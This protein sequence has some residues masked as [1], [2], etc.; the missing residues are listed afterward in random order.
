M[1]TK[2]AAQGEQS[3]GGNYAAQLIPGVDG[4]LIFGF[5]N[6][7]ITKLRYCTN[8]ILS[9]TAGGSAITVFSANSIFDPDVTNTGHQPMYH[10]QY[11]AIYKN[12]A[13]LGSRIQVEFINNNSSTG[14]IGSITGDSNSTIPTS[15]DNRSEQSNSVSVACEPA[16]RHVLFMNYSPEKNMGIVSSTD[17]YSQTPFGSSPVDQYY[18]GIGLCNIDPGASANAYIRVEVEYTV[19]CSELITNGGS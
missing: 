10:D 5:P 4:N 12:Y 2:Q 6:T 15:V 19:K 3:T 8:M 9:A 17:G 11:A 13:V 18:Y 7:I 16:S 14:V 1:E